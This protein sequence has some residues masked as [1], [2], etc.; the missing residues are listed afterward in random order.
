MLNFKKL[1]L[2]SSTIIL[3]FTFSIVAYAS[4]PAHRIGGSDRYQTSINTSCSGWTSSKYAIMATGQSFPDSLSS[5]PLSKKYNAPIL[6]IKKDSLTDATKDELTRLN[7][8]QVFIVGGT[9]VISLNIENELNSMDILTIRLAGANRYVTSTKIAQQLSDSKEV[10]ITTGSNFADAVSISSIAAIKG[11]PILLISKDNIDNSIKTYLA[12]KNITKT[13][14]IGD[15]QVISNNVVKQLPNAERIIGKDKYERNINILNKFAKYI[16]FSRIYV[17]NGEDF[18]DALSGSALAAKTSSAVL[19]TNV[20]QGILTKDFIRKNI[21][22]IKQVDVL[23]GSGAVPN[24]TLKQLGDITELRYLSDILKPFYSDTQ[25]NTE[26]VLINNSMY[27]AGQKYNKGYQLKCY[28]NEKTSFNLGG[29]YKSISG[30]IGLDDNYARYDTTLNVLGDDKILATYK[31]KCGELPQIL[32]LNVTGMLKL[33]FKFQ[34]DDQYHGRDDIDIVNPII[35]FNDTVLPSVSSTSNDA[36]NQYMSDT[37][38]PFHVDR[39]YNLEPVLINNSMNMAGQNYNKGYILK[40]YRDEKTTFNLGGNYKNING[41]IGLDD[42]GAKYDNTLNVLGDDKI[43]ATYKLKCG[44]LPQIFNLNV[45]GIS[46][47][48]FKLQN[49]DNYHGGDNIDIVNLIIK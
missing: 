7:V 37:I 19:L 48:D 36:T 31:L 17:A 39:G 27:M 49:D 21:T 33:D 42:N 25:Y 11:M 23:G 13:Y 40:C 14:V 5:A 46:K 6:L 38:M 32:D 22:K 16:D 29:K 2:Y 30:L 20:K 15:S 47:L 28:R 18:P 24:S 45:T 41:L 8:S 34:N 43:L 44:E 9:G 35:D 10:V 3:S 1:A 4:T 26:P 12:N